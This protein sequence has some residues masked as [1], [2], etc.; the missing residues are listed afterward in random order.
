V[1]LQHRHSYARPPSRCR[2][3]DDGAFLQPGRHSLL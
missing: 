2:G 3:R 1:D